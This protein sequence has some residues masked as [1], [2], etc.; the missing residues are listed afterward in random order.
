MKKLVRKMVSMLLVLAMLL[1][2]VPFAA[3]ADRTEGDIAEPT[4][5]P[6][7]GIMEEPTNEPLDE[8]TN[9]IVSPSE[10]DGTTVPSDSETTDAEYSEDTGL[11]EG[12]MLLS[13]QPS[14]DTLFFINPKYGSTVSAESALTVEWEAV[15]GAYTYK[16]SLRNLTMDNLL[17]SNE[18]I[19][20]TTSFTVPTKYLQPNC[21][22]RIWVGAFNAHEEQIAAGTLEVSTISTTEGLP[23]LVVNDVRIKPHS[24][25][26]Y[27]EVISNGGS[28]ITEYGI[29]EGTPGYYDYTK[30]GSSTKTS[31]TFQYTMHRE[32]CFDKIEC[33]IYARNQ[34]GETVDG[35]TVFTPCCHQ[36]GEMNVESLYDAT[37]EDIGSDLYHSIS[38]EVWLVETVCANMGSGSSEDGY[39]EQYDGH[40]FDTLS[41][42]NEVF[43]SKK[44]KKQVYGPLEEHYYSSSIDREGECE[45][46]GHIFNRT[47]RHTRT[48]E[49]PSSW[50]FDAY[51]Y[52][53]YGDPT[54]HRVVTCYT[55][56]SVCCQDCGK[57]LNTRDEIGYSS[58]LAPHFYWDD[59]CEYCGRKETC[60]HNKVTPV[61]NAPSEMYHVCSPVNEAVHN[62]T[63]RILIG[64]NKLVRCNQCGELLV[65][66]DSGYLSPLYR[67]NDAYVGYLDYEPHN[68]IDDVCT[69][70]GY[71]RDQQKTEQEEPETTSP[72]MFI[73]PI[74]PEA[75]DTADDVI[76]VED[77]Y[78]AGN[79]IEQESYIMEKKEAMKFLNFLTGKNSVKH[80]LWWYECESDIEDFWKLLTGETKGMTEEEI[81]QTKA[82]FVAYARLR[83]NLV[84]GASVDEEKFR[85]GMERLKEILESKVDILDVFKDEIVVGSLLDFIGVPGWIDDILDT[86]TWHTLF[87]TIQIFNTISYQDKFE[88]VLCELEKL[89][90][91]VNSWQLE[92][93]LASNLNGIL[94]GD[95]EMSN[96][97]VGNLDLSE[98]NLQFIEEAKSYAKIIKEIE[99]TLE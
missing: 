8:P 4:V 60:Q 58:Y 51:R 44:V 68:F 12:I 79:K 91:D 54:V 2:S 5:E 72:P 84:V 45:D 11:D 94:N 70:C 34:N 71:K 47:C 40:T 95:I 78:Q 88:L 46:C 55:E 52:E 28:K 63:S 20:N 26:I 98:Y 23:E 85:K 9:E 53:D 21:Q 43:T 50:D 65:E 1:G 99:R 90:K 59:E 64:E 31:F 10:P 92:S 86:E 66:E 27:G 93:G 49:I 48:I 87:S 36:H 7:E 30:L 18:K 81:K 14:E 35:I 6:T 3:L 62:M 73:E 41:Y 82:E 74:E 42:C 39:W 38:D 67:Y 29:V 69:E 89:D 19:G 15:P 61:E 22:F 24:F 37:Y 16:V 97:Y 80:K 75:T 83:L 57:V 32:D 25:T 77:K 17:Y 56:I 96:V 76:E 33:G 13:G